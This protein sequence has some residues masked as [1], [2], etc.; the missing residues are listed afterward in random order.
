MNVE[1]VVILY[2]ESEANYF[3]KILGLGVQDLSFNFK[4]NLMHLF[5]GACKRI[6]NFLFIFE[7]Q[8]LYA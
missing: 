6:F 7:Y 3:V 4:E 2:H 1:N 8:A 5:W